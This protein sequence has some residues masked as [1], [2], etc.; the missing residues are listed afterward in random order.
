MGSEYFVESRRISSIKRPENQK[1]ATVP[2]LVAT[3]GSQP[4]ALRTVT[5]PSTRFTHRIATAT[6][7][8]R[9]TSDKNARVLVTSD[10]SAPTVLPSK[11]KWTAYV[12]ACAPT[13]PRKRRSSRCKNDDTPSRNAA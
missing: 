3:T 11:K 9:V 6:R 10:A 7:R 8:D 1:N 5:K 12:N 13:M 4:M 2:A